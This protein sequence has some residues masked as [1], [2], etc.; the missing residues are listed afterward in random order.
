MISFSDNLYV[1]HAISDGLIKNAEELNIF[2]YGHL[3]GFEAIK[4]IYANKVRQD[5]PNVVRVPKKLLET[6]IEKLRAR[7]YDGKSIDLVVKEATQ[8]LGERLQL[9]KSIQIHNTTERLLTKD[10]EFTLPSYTPRETNSPDVE[11]RFFVELSIKPHSRNEIID[12]LEAHDITVKNLDAVI[13][14]LVQSN[15]I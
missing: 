6:T 2:R 13:H 5:I 14:F 8:N 4:Q 15:L 3:T 9:L 11:L 1:S 7:I 10:L 12:C